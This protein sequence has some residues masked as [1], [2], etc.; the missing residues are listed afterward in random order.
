MPLTIEWETLDKGLDI[1]EE[2]LAQVVASSGAGE[3]DPETEPREPDRRAPRERRSAGRRPHAGSGPG[4]QVLGRHALRHGDLHLSRAAVQPRAG[5]HHVAAHLEVARRP[6]VQRHREDDALPPH[7]PAQAVHHG[8]LRLQPR[9]RHLGPHH[10]GERDG[11]VQRASSSP[12]TLA[13]SNA[14]FGY[15]GDKYYFDIDIRTHFGLDKYEGDIIPYWKTETVEAMDAFRH[16]PGYPTGAGECVSLATLYAAALF[17]VGEV[18]LSDIFLMATPAPLAELRRHGRR[19]PHQQPPP[20]DQEHVVQRHRALRP[21]PPRPRERAGHRRRPRDRLHPHR[22]PRGHHRPGGLR[23]LLRQ[24]AQVP[25]EPADA[26]DARQLPPPQPRPAEVLPVPLAQLRR[27]P[28]H[29]DGEAAR[30]TSGISPTASTTTPASACSWRWPARTSPASRS[31]I[32]SS[33]TTWSSS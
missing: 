22:L 4:T 18:P 24:A 28:L 16:K 21:G 12:E 2:T 27:G 31:R 25:A 14:L 13:Q 23:P 7:H 8:P 9:P 29:R 10:Q 6:L 30:S 26:R 1:M 17:I 5:Q 32:A 15:E 19:H 3:R 33:S 20:R 11:P